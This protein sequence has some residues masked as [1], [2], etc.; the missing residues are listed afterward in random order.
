ML[1]PWALRASTGLSAGRAHFGVEPERYTHGVALGAG[2]SPTGACE[3]Y[4]QRNINIYIYIYISRNIYLFIHCFILFFVFRPPS[5]LGFGFSK[6]Q[7]SS[8]S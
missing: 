1:D 6:A 5:S 4:I 3:I 8:K 7:G 2:G